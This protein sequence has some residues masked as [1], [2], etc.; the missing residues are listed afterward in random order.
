[1]PLKI[2]FS[3]DPVECVWSRPALPPLDQVAS[4]FQFF[5]AV[6]LDAWNTKVCG[7][8]GR[9]AGFRRGTRLDLK[10][11]LQ[12]LSASHLRERDKGLLRDILSGGVWNGFL[13]GHAR[14]EIVPREI[15]GEADGDGHLFW[16]CSHPPFVHIRENPELHGLMNRGLDAFSGMVGYLR[17]L[18]LVVTPLGRILREILII[19]SFTAPMR[20]F[21][22]ISC[23]PGMLTST[24]WIPWKAQF[25]LMIRMD[26]WKFGYR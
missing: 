3:W 20:L 12:L 11:S 15:V 26:R 16:D 14:G 5:K 1:M 24:F 19:I 7:D 10:G 8:L 22:M 18:V 25:L 23:V 21:L 17:W 9:R 13:L 6:I 4:P 2:G